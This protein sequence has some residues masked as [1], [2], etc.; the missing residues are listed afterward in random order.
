MKNIQFK[1]ANTKK[2]KKK[3]ILSICKLKNTQWK[4]GIKSQLKW[5]NKNIQNNDIHNLLYLKESLV[6]YNLL[7]KRKFLLKGKKKNYLYFD[8]IIVLKKYRNIKIGTL[9]CQLSAKI[10]K[11]AKLHSMLICQNKLVKF[12]K[13]YRWEKIIKT[14]FEILDHKYQ[15]NHSVMTFNH[16]NNITNENIKYFI[17]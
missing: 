13:K 15:K 8:T 16:T 17:Y 9:I 3:E 5:F 4:Y 6:G 14:N 12:Y 7:R 10:I 2:L 1:S 11:K